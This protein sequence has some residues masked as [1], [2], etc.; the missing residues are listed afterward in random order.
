MTQR[1]SKP[2]INTRPAERASVLTEALQGLGYA[3]YELPLLSL[4]PMTLDTGLKTQFAQLKDAK[5]VVV[6]S[7]IAVELGIQYAL[8]CD[9]SLTELQ[10]KQ[11]IAVG[12]STQLALSKHQIDSICPT[13]ETSEGMLQLPILND[14]ISAQSSTSRDTKTDTEN[15]TANVTIA[16]WRGIGGRTL[17]MDALTAQGC[18]VLNML[19]YHRA[20][21][22]YT[23]DDLK[24][25]VQQLPAMILISSEQSWKNWQQLTERMIEHRIVNQDVFAENQY[26]VLGERVSQVLRDALPNPEHIMTVQHLQANEID[27][28]VQN[29]NNAG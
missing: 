27:S 7:P 3:V 22:N 18:H 21:P 6:V 8:Q 14:L 17:M 4:E 28:V 10:T 2:L 11:W 23:I 26:V 24:Q 12:R 13:V 16:F 20:M 19:L 1:R 25:L 9:I 5:I 15:D 29:R